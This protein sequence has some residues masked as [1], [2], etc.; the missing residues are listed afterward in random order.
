MDF[1]N[2]VFGFVSESFVAT[3]IGIIRIGIRYKY[4]Q[5]EGSQ[6][7]GIILDTLAEIS[8]LKNTITLI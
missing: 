3:G 8:N 4:V 1:F 5:V 6:P 7:C 2:C